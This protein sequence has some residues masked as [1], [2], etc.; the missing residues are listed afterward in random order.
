[1]PEKHIPSETA[2]IWGWQEMLYF[3]KDQGLTTAEA[4]FAQI[5]LIWYDQNR[6]EVIH[7]VPTDLRTTPD[8]DM[9]RVIVPSR[10]KLVG[11]CVI[12]L[13][14]HDGTLN[15]ALTEKLNEKIKREI[16][17]QQPGGWGIWMGSLMEH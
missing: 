9:A 12:E 8:F 14:S 17:K 16:E 10:K 15:T 5:L 11:G 7:F 4:I 13:L 1:M 6:Q 2:L 3:V